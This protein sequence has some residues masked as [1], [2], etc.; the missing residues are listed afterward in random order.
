M[1]KEFKFGSVIFTFILIFLIVNMSFAWYTAKINQGITKELLTEGINI[2]LNTTE[3]NTITPD[4]LKEGVLTIVDGA[5][6]LPSDYE[7]KKLANDKT[8][9]ESFGRVVEVASV[10]EIY[11][12]DSDTL[13]LDFTLLSNLDVETNVTEYFVISYSLLPQGSPKG[14]M[15]STTFDDDSLSSSVNLT[16]EGLYD[17]YIN[18]SFAMCDEM[19]PKDIQTLGEITLTVKGTLQKDS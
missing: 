14:E 1:S 2:Y 7:T 13:T 19:L 8:Y 16:E 3:D 5:Y 9:V 4:R 18:I 10:V 15:T 11:L 12:Y 6:V 17:L